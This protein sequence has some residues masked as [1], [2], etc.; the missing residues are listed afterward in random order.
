M[1]RTTRPSVGLFT[2][3]TLPRG[4]VVHTAYLADA[5]HDAGW[6]ATVYALDKD[7][8]GFFRPLRAKVCLVPAAPTPRSTADLVRVRAVE[9]A[10][11]LTRRQPAHDV[12]HAEDC[13]TA[14]GL[15]QLRDHGQRL[16]LVRTVHHVER[17]DDPYLAACQ[18]RSIR[19]AAVCL[20]V[21]RAAVDDVGRTFGVDA[22]LVANGV[23]VD[24][25][26]LPDL[27]R[28]RT[29]ADR[30]GLA[31]RRGPLLLAVGGVEERKNTLRTLRAFAR[32]HEGRPGARLVILG[33]ATVLDHGAYRAAFDRELAAMPPAARGAVIETGVVA[34]DDVPAIF[35]LASV[36]VFPSLHEGFGL[37]ALEALAARVP[38]VASN[39][40]PLTEFLDASCAVLVDPDSEDAIA[41][42]VLLALGGSLDRV[43]AGARVAERHS[44]ER[45]AM[46][47][48]ARYRQHLRARSEPAAANARVCSER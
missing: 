36:L 17:F 35:A 27:E 18:E 4:S 8:R 29:W 42:G 41:R 46:A 21:S 40:P 5:L 22:S 32:V 2:Y 7:R 33:G 23:C 9:M 16:E 37:A 39:R 3:S 34:D 43:R 44:W 6:D 13:L 45:V 26:A 47:H 14:N 25:F 15:L 30:L 28:V 48:V 11:Y 20:A 19:E 10:D 1:R 24:R 12:W 31:P 38:L